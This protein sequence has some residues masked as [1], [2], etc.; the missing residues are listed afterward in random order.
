MPRK[1]NFEYLLEAL[2]ALPWWANLLIGATGFFLFHSVVQ[3][4][5]PALSAGSSNMAPIV[6]RGFA[7]GLQY[8]FPIVFALAS[9]A[10]LV[11]RKHRSS[12]LDAQKG[13]H[14]I[15]ELTWR[16]FEW[17]VGE[18]YRRQ[19]YDVSETPDGPDGGVDLVAR[20]DGEKYLIQC[21]HWKRHKIDVRVVREFLGVLYKAGASGGTIVTTGSFTEPA[22]KEAAGQ[23]LE[24]I[25]GPALQALLAEIH[26]EDISEH[27]PPN[28]PVC[29]Q[30]MVKRSNR[31]TGQEFWGCDK[32]PACRGTR[33]AI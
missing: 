21:K 19:G 23:A 3:F 30:V 27:E 8:A 14:I 1:S 6:I 2:S 7:T 4:S 12:L 13:T 20:K 5:A 25:D 18:A 28:C 17:M 15:R 32:F 31:K 33:Q 11:R 22:R 26:S 10:S 29:G 16:E 24:L 9:I